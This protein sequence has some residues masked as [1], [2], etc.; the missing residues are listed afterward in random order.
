MVNRGLQGPQN[1]VEEA[2]GT[3]RILVLPVGWPL[4]IRDA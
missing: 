2:L 1:S 4:G 3:E